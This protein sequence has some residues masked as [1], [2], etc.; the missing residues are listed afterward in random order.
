M[1]RP[2]RFERP[3]PWFVAK[4]SIQLSYG[5]AKKRIIK[6]LVEKSSAKLFYFLNNQKMQKI[7]S[8]FF[9]LSRARFVWLL[10]AIL[11]FKSGIGVMP[12]FEKSASIASHIVENRFQ[13]PYFVAFL[14]D[15]QYLMWSYLSPLVMYCLNIQSPFGGFFLHLLFACLF[16]VLFFQRVFYFLSE[17]CARHSLIL[18]A[19]FP[20]SATAYFWVGTDSLTLLL[21]LIPFFGGGGNPWFCCWNFIGHAAF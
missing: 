17:S 19:M 5:R 8:F 1:A 2:E 18:F 13:L 15:N 12:N 11:I 20:V 10:W 6:V 4:Y 21:M 9:N 14:G 3:T 7:E 16:S